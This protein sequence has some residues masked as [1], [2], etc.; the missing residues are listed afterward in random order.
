MTTG[1]FFPIQATMVL[2]SLQLRPA[3]AS[4]RS[5]SSRSSSA[6][7]A[8][9]RP[10][11]SRKEKSRVPVST[12][13]GAAVGGVLGNITGRKRKKRAAAGRKKKVFSAKLTH[14]GKSAVSAVKSLTQDVI[15]PKTVAVERAAEKALHDG[16]V[17]ARRF[18]GRIVSRGKAPAPSARSK[19]TSS[20]TRSSASPGRP[21]PRRRPAAKK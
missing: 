20:Q 21:A 3:M 2:P 8:K 9:A 16:T 14:A 13:V 17:A 5:S 19:A 12:L 7:K 15:V 10:V 1:N 6:S 11:S 4:H 18:V